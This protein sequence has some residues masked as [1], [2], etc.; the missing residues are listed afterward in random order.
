MHLVPS[1]FTG[2]KLGISLHDTNQPSF[3]IDPLDIVV[4]VLFSVCSRTIS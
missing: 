3:N 1:F 4:N 2:S